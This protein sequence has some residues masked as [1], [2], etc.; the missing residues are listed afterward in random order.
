MTGAHQN[1]ASIEAVPTQAL[2][3]GFRLLILRQLPSEMEPPA[4]AL[5]TQHLFRSPQRVSRHGLYFANAFLPEIMSWLTELLGRLSVHDDGKACRN[6]RWPNAR[7]HSEDR[8]WPNG[9]HTV[10]WF[11][12]VLFPED[13]AW[14]AFQRR[15]RHRLKGEIEP[16]DQDSDS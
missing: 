4:F 7:W 10:E 11:V 8:L 6:K 9:A 12:D 1:A 15:W 5:I 14:A 16:Q 3:R 13:A 2:E